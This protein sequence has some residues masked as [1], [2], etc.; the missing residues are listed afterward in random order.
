[1]HLHPLIAS[2]TSI[3]QPPILLVQED[4]RGDA[5]SLG[6]T[7]QVVVSSNSRTCN[8]QERGFF[9]PTVV[10]LRVCHFDFEH[11]VANAV[12][13]INPCGCSNTCDYLNERTSSYPGKWE[14]GSREM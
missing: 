11:I 13:M 1:M 9:R 10:F 2:E 5:D 14:H 12:R 4:M 7:S 3:E 8:K 6:T